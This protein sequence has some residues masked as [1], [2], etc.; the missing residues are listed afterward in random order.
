M[1][2]LKSLPVW[3]RLSQGIAAAAAL[4][5]G[6][7]ALSPAMLA[8]SGSTDRWV[9]TWSTAEAGRPQNPVPPA[10]ALA[11]FM[12]SACPAPPAPAVPAVAPAPGQTFAPTPFMHFTNQTLRQIVHTS[13]GGS[14]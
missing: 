5:L 10:P 6:L 11:P 4:A 1:K 2:S 8:Q 14:K 3:G 13:S 12:A 9:G 7:P